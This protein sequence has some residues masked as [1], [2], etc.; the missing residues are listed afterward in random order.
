M[1]FKVGDKVRVR[2]DLVVG[3]FYGV[4]SFVDS[5]EYCK[6]EVFEITDVVGRLV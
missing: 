2:E 1:K 3:N 5:M 6:G 4:G